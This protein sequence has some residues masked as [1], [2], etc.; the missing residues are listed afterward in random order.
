MLDFS[1]RSVEVFHT[2]AKH[3][4]FTTA[5]EEL[6]I[7]QSSVSKIIARLEGTL[8]TQLFER[9]SH[10]VELTPAG[11][12]LYEELRDLLPQFQRVFQ[13]LSTFGLQFKEHL[14]LS[15][16]S[17]TCARVIAAFSSAYP[18]IH[19]TVSQNYDPFISF[20]ALM[21]NDAALWITHSLLIPEDYKKHIE[22]RQMYEDPVYVVL[23]VDHPLAGRE[24][25]SVKDLKKET[26][27]C[28]S[29]HTMSMV[30]A[31][32]INTGMTLPFRDMRDSIN[33]R[34]ICLVAICSGQGISL[35]YKS[36]FEMISSNKIVAIPLEEAPNCAVVAAYEKNRQ[37]EDH[38]LALLSYFSK[39]WNDYG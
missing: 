25:L 10:G 3:R 13:D 15:M 33:T 26:I 28:H 14:C 23:P 29:G 17:S 5:A 30:R 32:S 34:A 39:Y 22:I 18:N 4:S 37:L 38:E 36:D 35:F 19:F 6:Y 16:P 2:V 20:N 9:S 7:S 27:I 1:V 12:F 24:S 11:Q 8:N 21:R 31:L